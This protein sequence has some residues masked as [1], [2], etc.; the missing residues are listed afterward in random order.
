MNIT[1]FEMLCHIA[2]TFAMGGLIGLA[3]SI[4]TIAL[5]R[6]LAKR[7][8]RYELTYVPMTLV[9]SKLWK[10]VLVAYPLL[11]GITLAAFCVVKMLK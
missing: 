8:E 10:C 11:F 1:V 6:R 4:F 2:K 5:I 7:A 9:E 3:V